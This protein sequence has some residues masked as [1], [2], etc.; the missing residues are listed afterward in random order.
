MSIWAV[1]LQFKSWCMRSRLCSTGMSMG[2]QLG[3]EATYG[4]AEGCRMSAAAA[5]AAEVVRHG[6]CGRLV[7][8]SSGE[9]H[10][11]LPA[12]QP[13]HGFGGSSSADVDGTDTA[14]QH[15]AA[16]AAAGQLQFGSSV[17]D[18]LQWL[19]VTTGRPPLQQ[20]IEGWLATLQQLPQSEHKDAAA[21]DGRSSS[22]S[23]K[24][25][26]RGRRLRCNLY[27]MGP[28]AL[29]A[30]AQVLCGGIKGLHFVQK[31]YQ[32]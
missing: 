13:L 14:A 12:L 22:I 11:Q 29:V 20:L 2:Q 7:A 4:A 15:A 1:S 28:A 10:L 23:M 25:K 5:A 8:S 27:A 26:Q 18:Q 31:A 30:D 24:T 16:P 6:G 17:D 9:V 3:V 32:L 19:P 21:G